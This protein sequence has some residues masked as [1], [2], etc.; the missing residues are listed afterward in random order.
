MKIELSDTE[1]RHLLDMVYIGNWILNATRGSSRIR[2]YDKVQSR[3]FSHC[4]EQN[5]TALIEIG[6]GMFRPS[7]AFENGGIHDAIT[8]YEDSV[9]FEILAEELA[10]RDMGISPNGH[11]N[12]AEL[13]MRIAE[14]IQEFEKNGIKNI[15]LEK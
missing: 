15:T 12:N 9:F 6:Y 13:S 10:H 2:D 5:M 7:E 3:I 1:Y 8:H 4:I 11:E 14:Y